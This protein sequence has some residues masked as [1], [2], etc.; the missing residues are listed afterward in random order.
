MKER[1][2][3]L[4]NCSAALRLRIINTPYTHRAKWLQIISMGRANKTLLLCSRAA[5]IN[6]FLSHG[7]S[8]HLHLG[9]VVSS[10]ATSICEYLVIGITTQLPV[11]GRLSSTLLTK[12]VDAIIV[13]SHS[14]IAKLRASVIDVSLFHAAQAII[15]A[16]LHELR[17]T[18]HT[19]PRP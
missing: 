10:F 2:C 8:L 12:N 11:T 6:W 19:L 5:K 15:R 13:L 18:T 4:M 14:D 1:T 17:L 7:F 3:E 9:Q 16:L